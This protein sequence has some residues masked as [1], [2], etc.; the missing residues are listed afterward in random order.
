MMLQSEPCFIEN[1]ILRVIEAAAPLDAW[2]IDELDQDAALDAVRSAWTQ[3]SD[4][5]A[6]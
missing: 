2:T 4:A 3:S 1:A 6:G 5:S